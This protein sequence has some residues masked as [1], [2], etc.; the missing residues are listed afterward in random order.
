MAYN[1]H[2]TTTA[3]QMDD[4]MSHHEAAAWMGERNPTSNSHQADKGTAKQAVLSRHKVEG[5]R[6]S[7]LYSEDLGFLPM[8]KDPRYTLY[9]NPKNQKF[10]V[11]NGDVLQTIEEA[12]LLEHL[13]LLQVSRS[14]KSTEVRFGSEKAAQQFVDGEISLNGSSFTFRSNAQRRLMVSIHGVYPRISN[15]AL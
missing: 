10:Y 4:S 14:N 8:Q 6:E 15:A 13:E 11:K 3:F 5:Q 2:A 1:E 9:R 12:N 7:L